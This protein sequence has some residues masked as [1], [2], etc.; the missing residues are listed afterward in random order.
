MTTYGYGNARIA[1]SPGPV[2][3]S[4][5]AARRLHR[6]WRTRLP[7]AIDSQTLIANGV[8]VGRR[9]RNLVLVG[10]EHGV[11]AALDVR[12][13]RVV[14]RRRVGFRT[15]RPSCQASPDGIFGVTG[16]MVADKSASRLYVVDAKGLAW[17]LRLD[18]G[19]VVRGWPVRVHADGA[20]FDW[21]ALTLSRGR[22][23]VPLA[24]LCDQGRYYGGIKAIDVDHPERNRVWETTGGTRA[25]AGGIWGWGGLSVDAGTGDVFA[26]S[27]NSIGTPDEA[28]GHA[29]QVVRLTPSLTLLQHNYPLRPPFRIADRDFG[30][31]PV[32]IRAP[33]CPLQAIA[34]NKDGFLYRYAADSISRGPRQTVRVANSTNRTIPLY[35]MP[36]YDPSTRR[37]VLVSPTAPPGSP[38]R[39]GIQTFV[40]SPHCQLYPSWQQSFDS[41][42]A[43]SAPTIAEGVLYI[44][45]GRNGVV[46]AY[47][48]T[49]GQRLWAAGLGA[50]SFTAPSVADGRLLAGNWR[51]DLWSF[52]AG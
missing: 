43:G 44:G 15:I 6:S 3:I 24:S 30:T 40:L 32:L 4:V 5:A 37:L 47:R 19:K 41:P 45:T 28:E 29:E 36:A 21:G 39:A 1:A 16:T 34:I 11:V 7:G 38:L 33:G 18:D 42:D 17:A 48:L 26:A 23:Y 52:R 12:N 10:T 46:R 13:G 9:S 2:G 51:G 31:V 25:W 35:G 22:L 20:D 49:D 27:G 14:W 8:R 50:T